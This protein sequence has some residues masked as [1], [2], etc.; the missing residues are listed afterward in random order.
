MDK[1]ILQSNK[2]KSLTKGTDQFLCGR[3]DCRNR[4][5]ACAA[6]QT[7]GNEEKSA[8]SE[9]CQTARIF[10][11]KCTHRRCPEEVR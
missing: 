7:E 11:D 6:K 8:E 5:K 1:G 2:K 4:K 3:A 9:A 10:Q